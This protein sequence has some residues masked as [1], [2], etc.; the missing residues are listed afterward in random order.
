MKLTEPRIMHVWNHFSWFIL[1]SNFI[2]MEQTKM[3]YLRRVLVIFGICKASY[4]YTNKVKT[5][6]NHSFE[7]S[8]LELATQYITL[9]PLWPTIWLTAVKDAS[10]GFFQRHNDPSGYIGNFWDLVR[11]WKIVWI[12]VNGSFFRFLP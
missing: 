11:I 3:F 1:K 8:I 7:R 5:Y 2:W 6:L 4:G 10:L 12:L 9:V